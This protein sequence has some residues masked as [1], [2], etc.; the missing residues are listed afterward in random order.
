VA[1]FE[2]YRGADQKIRK[3]RLTCGASNEMVPDKAPEIKRP[4]NIST[5]RKA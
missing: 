5:K 2:V 4:Q 3:A 1:V